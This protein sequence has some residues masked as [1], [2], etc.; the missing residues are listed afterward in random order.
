MRHTS[1]T[2]H[3]V[4]FLVQAGIPTCHVHSFHIAPTS[5]AGSSM[6]MAFATVLVILDAPY[7]RTPVTMDRDSPF[8][9]M[10][11]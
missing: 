10:Y 11:A 8:T 4:E 2:R 1:G 9:T 7:S 3:L 6:C 5:K